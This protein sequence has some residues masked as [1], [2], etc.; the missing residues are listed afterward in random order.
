M[1]TPPRGIFAAAFFAVLLHAAL[2]VLVRP[3]TSRGISGFPVAP[4]TSYL[5]RESGRLPGSGI[6]VRV[7]ASPVLFSLPS[8]MGFSRE[9]MTQDVLTPLTF[10]QPVESEQFLQAGLG[11]DDAML[12]SQALMLTAQAP[13]I[14]GLPND[15]FQTAEKRPA[16]RRV[17][18][19]PELKERMVDGVVLPPELNQEVSKAWEIRAQISVGENGAVR[20][21]FLEQP[22]ESAAM[23]TRIL[24]L[25]HGLKFNPGEPV[26][27]MVEIYSPETKAVVEVTP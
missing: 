14:P 5:T 15:I 7:V 4:N 9:L 26:D 11:R 16:A 1:R 3:A 17:T 22:L 21:V 27:G 18:L 6:D 2:F 12:D 13:R 19:V 8:S 25:L 10:S 20:H 23:N 24:R